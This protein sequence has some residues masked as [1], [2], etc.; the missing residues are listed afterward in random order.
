MMR[1]RTASISIGETSP[2]A[3]RDK[4][5]STTTRPAAASGALRT[6]RTSVI[7]RPRSVIVRTRYMTASTSPQAR[8]QPRA[9]VNRTW[10][11]SLPESAADTAPTK[12]SAISRPNSISETRSTGLSTAR[13]ASAG[14]LLAGSGSSMIMLV[15]IVTSC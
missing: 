15:D 7:K 5:C 1:A 8:L 9:V 14:R 4:D 12:V 10:I 13:S 3:T 11:C 2:A 6:A